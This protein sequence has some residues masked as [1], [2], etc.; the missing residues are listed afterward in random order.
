[1]IFN[2]K[3]S[4]RNFVALFLILQLYC[5]KNP[6]PVDYGAE[7]INEVID[8]EI[9]TTRSV[10][11]KDDSTLLALS[12][13]YIYKIDQR[14]GI[15]GIKI[16]YRVN[17]DGFSED[18]LFR[19]REGNVI[20][21][22]KSYGLSKIVDQD[23]NCRFEKILEYIG[24][25]SMNEC[26]A[27]DSGNLWTTDISYNGQYSLYRWNGRS[28]EEKVN[29]SYEGEI[30]ADSDVIYMITQRNRYV[31]IYK[32]PFTATI[33]SDHDSI[34]MNYDTCQICKAFVVGGKLHLFVAVCGTLKLQCDKCDEYSG[35]SVLIQNQYALVRIEG[36]NLICRRAFNNFVFQNGMPLIKRNPDECWYQD[37]YC[38]FRISPVEIE[39][40]EVSSNNGLYIDKSGSV[41]MFF[42]PTL[43]SIKVSR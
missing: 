29:S 18:C 6:A 37:S 5:I 27:D 26:C 25:S 34:K 8:S 42:A 41:M 23:N 24:H 35:D 16:L 33:L 14:S 43:K 12:N 38:F 4:I 13:N 28:I 39:S 2:V 36:K 20:F 31:L 19:D 30:A 9:M 17:N 3:H 1:M 32:I 11:Q 15:S 10:V 7:D 40:E 21:F 22:D